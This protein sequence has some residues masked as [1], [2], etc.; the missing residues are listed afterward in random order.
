MFASLLNKGFRGSLPL[1]VALF[2]LSLVLT[3]FS[4]NA[5]ETSNYPD[6]F[7]NYF[8]ADLHSKIGITLLNFLFIAIGVLLVSLITSNQ[9]ITDKQ[10]Y[11]PVFIYLLICVSSVN[12]LQ[13]SAQLLTNV[14]VLFALY[15]LF[16]MYRQ[17]H[18]LKQMFEASFWL[19]CSAFITISSIIS[20]PVFFI[21]LLILR[22]FYWREWVVAL[23]GFFVPVFFYEALAYLCEFNRWYFFDSTGMFFSLLKV[24]SLSEYYLPLFVTMILLLLFSFFNNLRH[25]FGNTV[26]KQR[27]KSIFLWFI[28][29]SILAFFSAGATGSSILLS[30][31]IPLSFYTGDFFFGIKQRKL[32][33][34]FLAVFI[35]GVAVVVLGKLNL[36]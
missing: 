2:L 8:T 13:L 6:L 11:F 16:Y 18:V 22:P 23:L 33:N 1:L 14:F 21:S 29:F 27:S 36:L 17:E 5:L 7:Y 34:T 20:F 10:N 28:L 24:P 3:Y 9:E 32:T 31:A 4:P 19:S 35:L 30:V 15:Q 26:K 25:G 12:P